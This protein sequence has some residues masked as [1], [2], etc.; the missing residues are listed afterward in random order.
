MPETITDRPDVLDVTLDMILDVLLVF[1]SLA[2]EKL[3]HETLG[4]DTLGHG[5]R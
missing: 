2:R 5:A 1:E 3:A 4:R